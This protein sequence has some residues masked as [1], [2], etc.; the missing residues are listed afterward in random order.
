MTERIASYRWDRV[1]LQGL[2]RELSV[3]QRA[4]N[5]WLAGKQPQAL[6]PAA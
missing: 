4:E 2:L 5:R 6:A 1:E 3:A